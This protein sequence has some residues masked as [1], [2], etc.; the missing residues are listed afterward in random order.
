MNIE[1]RVIGCN[2]VTPRIFSTF[3]YQE[4]PRAR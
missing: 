1:V 4:I 2:L 3:K